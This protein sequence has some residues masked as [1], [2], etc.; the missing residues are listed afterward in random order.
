MVTS[1]LADKAVQLGNAIGQCCRARLQNIS[2]LDLIH[3]V[4]LDSGDNI[5]AQ[6]S[7]HLFR[8]ELFTAPRTH[9][10]V[11]STF[12]DRAVI[13]NDAVLTQALLTQL[14]KTIDTTRYG[15]QLRN[16]LNTAD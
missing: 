11:G 4:F 2:R 13:G 15:G 5:P 10:D 7:L 16:P 1:P 3:T 6:S 12:N 8:P 14:R 9:D